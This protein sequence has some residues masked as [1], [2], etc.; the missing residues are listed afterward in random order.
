MYFWSGLFLFARLQPL[1]TA[2]CS[3]KASNSSRPLPHKGQ[4][5]VRVNQRDKS[6]DVAYAAVAH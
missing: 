4:G 1:K 2:G 3:H 6:V 5:R